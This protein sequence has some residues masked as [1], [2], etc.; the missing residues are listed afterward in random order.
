MTAT[1][2]AIYSHICAFQREGQVY[3][4]IAAPSISEMCSRRAQ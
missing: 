3:A 4:R 1:T 2:R